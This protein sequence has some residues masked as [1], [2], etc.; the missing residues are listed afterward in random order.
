MCFCI[1]EEL[2]STLPQLFHKHLNMT[3]V[4]FCRGR[5]RDR[6]ARSSPSGPTPP[7]GPRLGSGMNPQPG[8]RKE[9]QSSG[10]SSSSCQRRTPGRLPPSPPRCTSTYCPPTFLFRGMG[11]PKRKWVA[12][13]SSVLS[14]SGAAGRKL[15]AA[16]L[17]SGGE[18]VDGVE[19]S[20]GRSQLQSPLLLLL[21]L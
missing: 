7:K 17:G 4:E 12:S 18:G 11:S 9:M 1:P 19:R 14:S 21:L 2:L 5:D 10:L 6:E 20:L 8:W 15:L 3:L 13:V 16:S